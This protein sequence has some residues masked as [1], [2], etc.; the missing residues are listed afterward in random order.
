M[1]VSYHP[2]YV[3]EDLKSPTLQLCWNYGM[4]SSFSN[5]VKSMWV[6]LKVLRD[7]QL[8]HE[9]PLQTNPKYKINSSTV[10]PLQ[11]SNFVKEFVP[12][13]WTLAETLSCLFARDFG[14]ILFIR[15]HVQAPALETLDSI[16]SAKVSSKDAETIWGD[17]I[18][19]TSFATLADCK[20][21]RHGTRVTIQFNG[22]PCCKEGKLNLIFNAFERGV[23]YKSKVAIPS[24]SSNSIEKKLGHFLIK[25]THTPKFTNL[26]QLKENLY[27]LA[28][29]QNVLFFSPNLLR[30]WFGWLRSMNTSW[31]TCELTDTVTADLLHASMWVRGKQMTRVSLREISCASFHWIYHMQWALRRMLPK[32][33]GPLPKGNSAFYAW[34]DKESLVKLNNFEITTLTKHLSLVKRMKIDPLPLNEDKTQN[35]KKSHTSTSGLTI[36]LLK[37]LNF[38]CEVLREILVFIPS[39]QHYCAD[40]Y[41]SSSRKGKNSEFFAQPEEDNQE[42]DQAEEDQADNH[43]EGSGTSTKPDWKE[44]DQWRPSIHGRNPENAID[45]C[46][47]LT[48]SSFL[49]WIQLKTFAKTRLKLYKLKRYEQHQQKSKN[50]PSPRHHTNL[51]AKNVDEYV[52][53]TIADKYLYILCLLIRDGYQFSITV[54]ALNTNYIN[55][56]KSATKRDHILCHQHEDYA[57]KEQTKLDPSAFAIKS[58]E[59]DGCHIAHVYGLLIPQ[60]T[61]LPTSTNYT[62]TPTMSKTP[63]TPITTPIQTTTSTTTT[64]TTLTQPSFTNPHSKT[65]MVDT[66][67]VSR[68]R[69]NKHKIS[70]NP[71]KRYS[72]PTALNDETYIYP[73]RLPLEETIQTQPQTEIETKDEHK[74]VSTLR[75]PLMVLEGTATFAPGLQCFSK[76]EIITG[77]SNQSGVCVPYYAQHIYRTFEPKHI[78]STATTTKEK[79]TDSTPTK[80]HGKKEYLEDS[81]YTRKIRKMSLVRTN[82]LLCQGFD[83]YRFAVTLNI[84]ELMDN[85]NISNPLCA[86]RT[87]AIITKGKMAEC[88]Y[89]KLKLNSNKLASKNEC[90][91][92]VG[93]TLKDLSLFCSY[94]QQDSNVLGLIESTTAEQSKL[95]YTT[96]EMYNHLS[97][98]PEFIPLLKNPNCLKEHTKHSTTKKSIN[99]PE[100]SYDYMVR[101]CDMTQIK[102]SSQKKEYQNFKHNMHKLP[103]WQNAWVYQKIIP[104]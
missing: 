10:Y 24:F 63:T 37:K 27:E 56:S 9:V 92:R 30:F 98:P 54:G 1:Y 77:V 82:G 101:E 73:D 13:G 69:I 88:E 18:V 66:S 104:K 74:Q 47:S 48:L 19:G 20:F 76:Q 4:P 99:L 81:K 60:K 3:Y 34:L 26:V 71:M 33:T 83:K 36:G 49:T 8:T 64:K 84:P 45:D 23:G 2:C 15:V 32:I 103:I 75:L 94:R 22:V 42:D 79:S 100:G 97:A 59:P 40:V 51:E 41:R 28:R 17:R 80:V 86:S 68:Q 90:E 57:I 67:D 72:S 31:K 25:D 87:V 78:I 44:E 89:F 7:G 5:I 12:N 95:F 62:V 35:K 50:I 96:L 39:I 11:D 102:H 55:P 70:Y 91:A 21:E 58:Y 16:P 46:E 93:C 52:F 6:P 53:E 65:P 38:W 14:G 29:L 85:T 61:W 43:T